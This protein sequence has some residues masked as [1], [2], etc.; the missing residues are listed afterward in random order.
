MSRRGFGIEQRA[1]GTILPLKVSPRTARLQ[2]LAEKASEQRFVSYCRNGSS[3][4]EIDNETEIFAQS[5]PM[6]GDSDVMK[7]DRIRL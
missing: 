3:C 1:G 2:A 4:L 7:F 5:H 6:L